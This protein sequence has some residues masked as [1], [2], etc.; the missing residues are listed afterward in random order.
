VEL[1]LH[2]PICPRYVHSNN[3]PFYVIFLCL[4]QFYSVAVSNNIHQG[5]RHRPVAEGD[6]VSL[7][8]V[9]SRF[10]AASRRF[11]KTLHDVAYA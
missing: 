7:S 9:D 11:E 8:S 4:N 2:S 6:G 1:Y 3:F 10:H 5:W